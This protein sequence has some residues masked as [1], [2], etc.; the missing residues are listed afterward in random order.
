M[1]L[2]KKDEKRASQQATTLDF[3]HTT[4]AVIA[5]TVA[6]KLLAGRHG[7]LVR[8]TNTDVFRILAFLSKQTHNRSSGNLKTVIVDLSTSKDLRIS[9][10]LSQQTMA[11]W[12]HFTKQSQAPATQIVSKCNSFVNGSAC[13]RLLA[14]VKEESIANIQVEG[15]IKIAAIRIEVKGD[16]I[17]IR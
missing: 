11:A 4:D 12:S 16:L 8:T 2:K 10:R 14:S 13:E 17:L 9:A 5:C 1:T 3:S 15:P 7:K 6:A